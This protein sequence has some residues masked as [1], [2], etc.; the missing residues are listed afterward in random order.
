MEQIKHYWGLLQEKMDEDPMIKKAVIFGGI[1]L[2]AIVLMYAIKSFKSASDTNVPEPAQVAQTTA[3]PASVQAPKVQSTSTVASPQASAA[4]Q[5]VVSSALKPLNALSS[6]VPGYVMSYSYAAGTRLEDQSMF[7]KVADLNKDAISFQ[8]LA[9]P[10]ELLSQQIIP[11]NVFVQ[12]K[13]VGYFAVEQQ[14]SPLLNVLITS[15]GEDHRVQVYIDDQVIPV[16]DNRDSSYKATQVTL[17]IVQTYAQGLHKLT[18]IVTANYFKRELPTAVR[19]SIKRDTDPAPTDLQVFREA[20]VAPV[21]PVQVQTA[22]ASGSGG[23]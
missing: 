13:A 2:A 20:P 21:T 6:M 22:P 4:P 18:V 10:D 12:T 17:P 11:G 1:A 3:V 7:A 9:R 19:I 14:S 23:V 8:F 16:I 15:G 5:Q